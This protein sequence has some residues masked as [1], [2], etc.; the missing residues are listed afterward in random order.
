M[1]CWIHQR[2]SGEWSSG[3]SRNPQ[4]RTNGEPNTS[5]EGEIDESYLRK[6]QRPS[7]TI[8]RDDETNQ[9]QLVE[10]GGKS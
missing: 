6:L 3:L 4:G 8:D 9:T 7:R 1:I 10:H 5:S 2:Y